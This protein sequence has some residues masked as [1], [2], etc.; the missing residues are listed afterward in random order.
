LPQLALDF[1]GRRL[2]PALPV[3]VYSLDDHMPRNYV[4]SCRSAIVENT[5]IAPNGSKTNGFGR[6]LP[7][8][9]NAAQGIV[10]RAQSRVSALVS[11]VRGN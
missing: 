7:H 1:V 2:F 6:G 11:L 3:G 9:A 10:Q 4:D 8:L 5:V